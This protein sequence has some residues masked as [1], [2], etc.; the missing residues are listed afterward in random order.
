MIFFYYYLFFLQNII[1]NRPSDS[2][3]LTPGYLKK[4]SLVDQS[5]RLI[6]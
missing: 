1:S 5:K 2:G 3:K 4:K 6:A